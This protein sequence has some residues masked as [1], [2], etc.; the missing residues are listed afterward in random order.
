[1]STIVTTTFGPV[2]GVVKDDVLLFSG[3]P[4]AA[5]PTGPLRFQAAQPHAGWEEVRSASRFGKAA[6]QLATGSMTAAVP[7][8]WSEDCLFLN[9]TTP[10]ADDQKRP[11]FFWIHGGGYRTGQGA[12]PWYNGAQF[13]KQGDI[14]T[15]SINY[16]M[17]ALGFTDLSRFGPQYATSGV[18]GIL[19]QITALEWV[20]DN[21]A[22]FGGDPSQVTIGGESA[23]AFAVSTLL[24]S[25]RAQGLFQRA[26]AQ[27]GAAQH[28]L[29]TEAGG[30]VTDALLAALQASDMADLQAASVDDILA[31]QAQIDLEMRAGLSS[32]LG[33]VAPFYPVAG[34]DVLPVSPL[35]AISRGMGAAVALLTGTNKD[36]ATL[37]VLNPVDADKLAKEAANYGGGQ[38][39]IACYKG[40]YPQA[41]TTELSIA[42]ATDFSFRIPALR[43]AEARAEAATGTWMYQFNWESR[44]GQLKATHALEI[45]FVFNNLGKP[46]VDVF[47]GPGAT[48]QALADTMHSAWTQFI[49]TGNPNWPAYDLQRRCT[50]VFDTESAVVFD[51]DEGR[52]GVWEG[53]R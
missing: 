6:P 43:L 32:R 40:L 45:P 27:S 41:S 20:R 52:R 29:T 7:V 10:A 36:E 53:I 30:I 5:A 8:P 4:Y 25:P 37:F 18:N 16:R 13:A 39:L 1:M 44:S 19:D 34:N 42:L 48:P 46:G 24:G 17:G 23:G 11:V 49:R 35:L 22:A 28:T 12:V 9:I 33:S 21:I 31:A 50:M 26:I 14:V 38:A 3:I 15:V 51:P 2:Q 47:L